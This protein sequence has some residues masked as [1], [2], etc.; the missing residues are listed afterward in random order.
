MD[1]QVG[2]LLDELD[3]LDL[4]K[5]TIVVLW[6]DHGWKLGEH[7]AWC[8][9]SNTENDTNAPLLLSVPGMKSAGARTDSLV[10]FVDIYPT[11][12]ELAGLPLP[13]HLE[14][15]SLKPLLDD[16]TR[17]WKSAAFSQYPRPAGKSGFGALMGYSMRTDRYRFTA[18]VGRNDHSKVDAVELYDHQTDPQENTN[19]ANL[20]ANAA[21]V[22]QLTMQWRKGWQGA[23]PVLAK[24]PGTP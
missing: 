7:D 10:E 16:P 18:W 3:R 20:P 13:A 21:L 5:N 19:I 12:S 17:P 24:E 1:A 14:G 9:H 23:K 4:R 8:K 11:L 2:K 22:E 6:G 15:S